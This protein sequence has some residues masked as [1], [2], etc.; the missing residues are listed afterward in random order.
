[1]IAAL[2]PVKT[3]RASKTRLFPGLA[4]ESVERLTLAMMTDVVAALGRVPGLARIAVVT[5]D[6][7]VARA[8][9]RVGAEPLLRPDPGLNPAVENACAEI[10]PA[11]GDGVLV[12]LGDVAAAASADLEILLESVATRGVALAPSSDGGTSALL[13]IPR[14]A[15]PA[16]FGPE[17]AK[18]HRE[19]AAR[20]G[21]PCRQVAL[22]SLAIDVD[23]GDD[24]LEILRTTTLGAHTRATLEALGMGER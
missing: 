20:A 9:R 10:A 17:S 5:P 4:R 13:R 7:V 6:E 11:S 1:M 21:V 15:I 16:R 3:L 2:V 12:V 18:R 23:V 22:P 19:E 14:D 8:A 24:A